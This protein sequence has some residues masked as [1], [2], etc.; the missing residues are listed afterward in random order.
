MKRR[1]SKN[2]MQA[3]LKQ[4]L[5]SPEVK[6]DPRLRDMPGQWYM[7]KATA[8]DEWILAYKVHCYFCDLSERNKIYMSFEDIDDSFGALRF[9][10]AKAFPLVF[11]R[12]HSH[13]YVPKAEAR[14]EPRAQKAFYPIS[15]AEL[16]AYLL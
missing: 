8:P 15:E 1:K 5:K 2:K 16:A 10:W 6:R 11:D 4:Y 14:F 13:S 7:R 3:A 12:F 9:G